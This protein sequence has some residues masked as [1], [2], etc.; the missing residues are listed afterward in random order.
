MIEQI[1]VLNFWNS[2]YFKQKGWVYKP[3]GSSLGKPCLVW[4]A[5][6]GE[7]T[8][9]NKIATG[10][11]VPSDITRGW[12]PDFTVFA[13]TGNGSGTYGPVSSQTSADYFGRILD[14]VLNTLGADPTRIYLAGLSGGGDAIFQ[15][16][17][18]SE[19]LSDAVAAV[20]PASPMQGVWEA[21]LAT[22]ATWAGKV[23]SYGAGGTGSGDLPFYNRLIKVNQVISNAGGVALAK[24]YAGA[25]HSTAVWEPFFAPTSDVWPWL[26][27]WSRGEDQAPTIASRYEFTVMSD[28]A[29]NY[30]K[31]DGADISLSG[32]PTQL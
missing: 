31:I 29:V 13:F 12:A 21:R 6:R 15:W 2:V 27:Q 7:A 20:L 23:R 18:T 24:A 1:P 26:L 30:T 11:T 14:Y 32:F 25:G 8:D 22:F 19:A 4:F 5:G 28:G 17:T 16:L 9:I 3:N 10:S